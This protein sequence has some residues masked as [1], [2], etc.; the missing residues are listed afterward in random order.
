[1]PSQRPV[2]SPGAIV[3]V[4]PDAYETTVVNLPAT[5]TVRVVW[6]GRE[7]RDYRDAHA[8][9]GLADQPP[10][11]AQFPASEIGGAEIVRYQGL[12]GIRNGHFARDRAVWHEAAKAIRR[13]GVAYIAHELRDWNGRRVWWAVSV[14]VDDESPPGPSGR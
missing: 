1:M 7:F 5:T 2:S 4:R 8:D 12:H 10:F 6:P 9:L 11:V 3:E 13:G 14:R